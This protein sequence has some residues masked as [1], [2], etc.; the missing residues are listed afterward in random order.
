MPGRDEDKRKRI[1]RLRNRLA[2]AAGRAADRMELDPD[3][4]LQAAQHN[5]EW[6]LRR[7]GSDS[8][9]AVNARIEVA[10]RLEDRGRFE[11]A[12]VLRAEISDL[13]RLRLGPDDPGTLTAEAFEG[14]DL[15]RLGRSGEALRAVR[16]CARRTH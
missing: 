11:E 5:L 3:S 15:D 4:A 7:K 16:T 10:E 9:F 1:P 14:L 12:S 13:L 2:Q 6:A 8:P